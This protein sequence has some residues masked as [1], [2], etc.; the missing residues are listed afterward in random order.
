ML[1]K[2]S[3]EALALG[4]AWARYEAK[5][6]GN[7]VATYAVSWQY[8]GS[9]Q[10]KLQWHGAKVYVGALIFLNVGIKT[11]RLGEWGKKNKNKKSFINT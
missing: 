6:H 11:I 10:N 2:P 5:P 4:A 8:G 1:L 9:R 3:T 7:T